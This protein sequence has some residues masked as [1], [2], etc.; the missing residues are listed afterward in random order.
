MFIS[1]CYVFMVV[2]LQISEQ[3]IRSYPFSDCWFIDIETTHD[4]HV[5]FRD[6]QIH[7][8]HLGIAMDWI[9]IWFI[10]ICVSNELSLDLY[11]WTDLFQ[12][13]NSEQLTFWSNFLAFFLSIGSLSYKDL[14]PNC[15][16]HINMD[17]ISAELRSGGSHYYPYFHFLNKHLCSCIN[18][19]LCVNVFT[20]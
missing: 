7:T 10:L 12:N 16:E 17:Q 15:F 20:N 3:L 2:F 14:N 8:F 5:R 4:R 19:L 9:C 18:G 13:L 1:R 6:C 11:I